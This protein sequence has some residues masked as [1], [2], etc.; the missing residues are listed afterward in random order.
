MAANMTLQTNAAEHVAL[1]PVHHRALL[2]GMSNMMRKELGAWFHTRRWLWQLLLW[3]GGL[4]GYLAVV[5]ISQGKLQLETGALAVSGM[6]AP[7][8]TAL[9]SFF[10]LIG[11]FGPSGVIQL[12]MDSVLG[13]KQSGTAAWVLSKPL[14]RPAFI[15]SKLIA[16]T[17]GFG[18]FM[19]LIPGAVAYGEVSLAAGHPLAVLPFVAGLGLI[20]LQLL[21]FLT[22]LL[23]LGVLF[24]QRPPML[25]IAM[26]VWLGIG[27]GG[28]TLA[29]VLNF[30]PE[31]LRQM[32]G[33][34]ALGRTPP[35]D[36]ALPILA[37]LAWCVLFTGVALRQFAHRA[38]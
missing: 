30:L 8:A 26:V 14:S 33:G 35:M 4:N 16:N 5:L 34:V 12:M 27:L 28:A 9:L 17:L 22:L 7:Y 6:D 3:V 24:D 10:A 1:Q 29:P 32:A 37:T 20:G 36:P 18:L 31:A 11:L 23:L 38:L 21:F 15:L 13:E 19:L 25:S 2:S